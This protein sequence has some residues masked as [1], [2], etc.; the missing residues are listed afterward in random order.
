VRVT[1]ASVSLVFYPSDTGF[2]V[3]CQKFEAGGIAGH[4]NRLKLS[5]LAALVILAL[6]ATKTT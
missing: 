1:P 3:A 5:E 2:I 4:K 6:P